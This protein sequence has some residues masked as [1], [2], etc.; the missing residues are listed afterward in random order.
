MTNRELEATIE[1]INERVVEKTG[2]EL[3]PLER[4]EI[5]RDLIKIYG[6]PT[7]KKENR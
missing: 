7:D 6:E 2:R 4:A 1:R 3:Q 5:R